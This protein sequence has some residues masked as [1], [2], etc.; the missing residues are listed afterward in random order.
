[1]P[2]KLSFS[3]IF[4]DLDKAIRI[5]QKRNAVIA[6][7]VSNV[8]TPKYKPKDINFKEALA[9]ALETDNQLNL[10]RTNPGHIHM[11]MRNQG[12]ETF[13]EK[14]EWNGYNWVNIDKE[15]TKLT[16]NNLMYRQAVETLLRKIALIKEVIKEG[17]Q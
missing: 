10:T 5:T 12:V 13:E 6:S 3:K 11:N 17:G 7:N 4:N 14:G 9:R 8:D 1:M 2:D 16:E 15:M